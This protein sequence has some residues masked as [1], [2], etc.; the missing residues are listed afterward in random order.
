MP[1]LK[2]IMSLMLVCPLGCLPAA[3]AEP[4]ITGSQL[5]FGQ[6]QRQT[7]S[8]YLGNPYK[9]LVSL[10]FHTPNDLGISSYQ[11]AY[12]YYCNLAKTQDDAN[13]QFAMGWLFSMGKGVAVNH[14]IAAYFFRQADKKGHQDAALWLQKSPGNPEL[15]TPPGCMTSANLATAADTEPVRA[16]TPIA[17]MQPDRTTN[18]IEFPKGPIFRLVQK[19][20]PQYEI[21]VGFAM[22]VIAVES[23]FDPNAVSAKNAQGLMQLLP[24]T[25]AR[26][27]VKDPFNPEQN[28]K[29]GLSYLRWLLDYFEGDVELVLAAY[30]AGEHM[31]LKYRGVPPFPETQQYIQRVSKYYKHKHHAY[32]QQSAIQHAPFKRPSIE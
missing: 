7:P 14:D 32:T 9:L 16:S 26:F 6:S 28:I 17:S 15:A 31:V 3:R 10:A 11:Q 12:D 24:Q 19:H 8:L 30:N 13:A 27:N 21:E 29:G 1:L 20:A 22:A 5:Q 23:G 25:Q 18:T 2:K 4:S